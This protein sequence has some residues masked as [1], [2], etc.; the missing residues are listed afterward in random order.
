MRARARRTL[1]TVL[2]WCF[3]K[4]AKKRM[5]KKC[6]VKLITHR[7]HFEMTHSHRKKKVWYN[8]GLELEEIG[9]PIMS[10]HYIVKL[11]SMTA[12]S[13][14]ESHAPWP[15]LG[16][17]YTPSVDT[18]FLKR[19]RHKLT[20]SSPHA[21]SRMTLPIICIHAHEYACSD[22]GYKVHA[23]SQYTEV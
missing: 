13:A 4:H 23:D 14:W 11:I 20:Q 22:Q 19:W 8:Y 16:D 17:A 5:P 2:L 7:K 21:S 18:R 10:V 12:L 3:Y 6:P 9:L 15:G 1:K